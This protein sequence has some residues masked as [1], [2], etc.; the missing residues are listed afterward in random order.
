MVITWKPIKQKCLTWETK[1]ELFSSEKKLTCFKKKNTCLLPLVNFNLQYCLIQTKD[2]KVIA[3]FV[4]QH[5]WRVSNDDQ[6]FHI[7]SGVNLKGW[8][9]KANNWGTFYLIWYV[10][11]ELYWLLINL[12]TI[13]YISFYVFVKGHCVSL[14]TYSVNKKTPSILSLLNHHKQLAQR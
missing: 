2:C 14:C 5:S 1:L 6:F 8:I 3:C 12:I 10:V 7:P 11:F 9:L 13:D 4:R